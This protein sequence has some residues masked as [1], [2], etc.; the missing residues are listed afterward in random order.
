MVCFHCNVQAELEGMDKGPGLRH[1][2]DNFNWKWLDKI[3]PDHWGKLVSNLF[4]LGMPNVVTP[5]HYDGQQNL[6][7][8]V[9]SSTFERFCFLFDTLKVCYIRNAFTYRHVGVHAL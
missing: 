4:I 2:Y 8:Q 6:F 7:T 9:G 5:A 3:K 1:D